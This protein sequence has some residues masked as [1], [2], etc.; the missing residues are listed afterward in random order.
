MLSLSTASPPT[1][2]CSSG[3]TRA[4]SSGAFHSPPSQRTGGSRFLKVLYELRYQDVHSANK[5]AWS[6][7]TRSHPLHTL[8][9]PKDLQ[10]ASWGMPST[11]A[12]ITPAQVGRLC[13]LRAGANLEL[14]MNI[15]KPWIVRFFWTQIHEFIIVNKILSSLAPFL[16]LAF[17]LREREVQRSWV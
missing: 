2:G 4:G 12:L 5:G 7:L 13:P 16:P 6:L 14:P 10:A 11:S 15:S 8:H 1:C 3:S 17:H 9:C